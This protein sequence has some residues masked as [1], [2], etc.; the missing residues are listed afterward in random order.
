[1]YFKNLET[2]I[3]DKIN[4]NAL[5]KTAAKQRLANNRANAHKTESRGMDMANSKGYRKT[6][7]AKLHL[8]QNDWERLKKD[9]KHDSKVQTRI[10]SGGFHLPGSMKVY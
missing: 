9:S 2:S 8:R 5:M 7:E 6:A 10:D 4:H 3:K 1:M